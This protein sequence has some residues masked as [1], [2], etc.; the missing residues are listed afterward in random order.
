LAE[1]LLANAYRPIR[2]SLSLEAVLR[3]EGSLPKLAELSDFA[4]Q[5]DRALAAIAS[6]L[7]D[8]WP[9]QLH[10]QH[11]AKRRH[12]A[13]VEMNPKLA[14][15]PAGLALADTCDRIA[16]NVEG[17]RTC[18]AGPGRARHRHPWHWP[19]KLPAC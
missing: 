10:F 12:A 9:L 14:N 7:G 5:V 2:T 19:G 15:S 3:D 11:P 16:D 1:S 18:C 17:R 13:A 6:T 4:A 8:D